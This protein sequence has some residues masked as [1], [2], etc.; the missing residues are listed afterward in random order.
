MAG[1]LHVLSYFAFSVAPLLSTGKGS[2]V[3]DSSKTVKDRQK[4]RQRPPKTRLKLVRNIHLSP[5]FCVVPRNLLLYAQAARAPRGVRFARIA[6]YPRMAIETKL[7]HPKRAGSLKTRRVSRDL[8][9]NIT[10][11]KYSL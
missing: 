8:K 11:I 9:F 3:Q 5:R 2:P 4:A 10:G 6:A 1:W 7:T